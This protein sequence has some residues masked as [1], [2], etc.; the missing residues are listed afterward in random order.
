[1][2]HSPA[3]TPN[4]TDL[5]SL[6]TAADSGTL[7]RASLRLHISQPALSKRLQALE[8]LVGVE[9]L[10][11]SPR[12]VALTPAGRRLYEQARPLLDQA[13]MLDTLVAELRRATAPVR[14]AA[15]HSA[16]EAFVT[17]ATATPDAVEHLAVELV[18][19]NSLVVRTLVA[20]G[21]ADLGVA[22]SRE[23]AT[24]QPGVRRLPLADDAIVCAVPRGHPWAQRRR[25]RQAEFLRT[26][27]VVRDPSSNAR[28]T[29]DAVLRRRGLEAAPP[30]AQAPTPAAAQREALRRSAP[31]LASRHVLDP[32]FFVEI[33]VDG[34]AFPRRFE[35]VLPAS[36]EPPAAVRE[37]MD[38]LREAAGALS[39]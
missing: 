9:L 5:R 36:G 27:M 14:L 21:R 38:R 33:E 26:P 31:L 17:E 11:R 24:P 28:W 20:D 1:M 25:I 22:P 34:L 10:E 37:L 29:V 18:I 3:R 23:G 8:Q 15:S 35:L 6:V 19:A 39:R 4:L 16:S 2:P 7:G 32:Q 13:R 30:L 12:G